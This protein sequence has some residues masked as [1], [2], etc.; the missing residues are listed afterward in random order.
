MVIHIF[1]CVVVENDDK[2]VDGVA[3][4]SVGVITDDTDNLDGVSVGVGWK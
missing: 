1:G 3:A 4:G 2:D